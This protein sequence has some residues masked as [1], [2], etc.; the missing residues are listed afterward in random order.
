M[1]AAPIAAVEATAM[2]IPLDRP[3]ASALGTYT[4]V[5]C[6]LVRVRTQDGHVGTG[7]NIGL[8]GVA[9]PAV[10]AYITGELAPL[11]IGQDALAPEALWRRMWAPNKA[12]MRA[13]LGVWG[14]SAVDIAVWDIVG[15]AAGLPLNRLLGGFRQDVPVYGSGGWHTLDDDEIVADANAYLAKGITAYKYKVGTRRDRERTAL[16]RRELGD[17]ITL[18]AD[19]NQSLDVRG[20]IELSRMLAEYGVAWLEEPVVADSVDDLG[21]VAA[22]SAVPVAAGEN[23][24]FRWGFREIC[25]RRAAAFLQP[26]ATRCGG[27]TEFRRIG[28]LADSFGL[29]LSSHLWHELS[30]SLVGAFPSGYLVEYAELIPPD[31]LTREFPVVDGCIRVPDVPGHGVAFADEAVRR[32]AV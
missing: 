30:I 5:D 1:P 32:F 26:D 2:P 21:R 29:S 16:L 10:A 17:D 6:V 9:S 11:A 8:G 4:V 13:G 12:R 27:V 22:G 28:H 23:A 14:L 31:V 20:A 7:F 24:Y 3:I 15:Q 19:A 18:F 25:E